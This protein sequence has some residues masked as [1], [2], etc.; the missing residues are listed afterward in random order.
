M[1]FFFFLSLL[2]LNGFLTALLRSYPGLKIDM[3]Y[4]LAVKFRFFYKI[5]ICFGD[6]TQIVSGIQYLS[7]IRFRGSIFFLVHEFQRD[8]A[9][10]VELV[11]PMPVEAGNLCLFALVE[12]GLLEVM[13]S[14]V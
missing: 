9:K 6:K 14:F 2:L 4:F 7:Q 12:Q 3:L 11:P 8:K 13:S 10:N 1:Y 5:Y